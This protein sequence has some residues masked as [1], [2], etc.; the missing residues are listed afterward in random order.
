MSCNTRYWANEIMASKANDKLTT[1]PALQKENNDKLAAI[2]AAREAQDAKWS[3]TPANNQNSNRNQH[4]TP[5]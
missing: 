5:K 1:N 2:I 4:Q 3:Y